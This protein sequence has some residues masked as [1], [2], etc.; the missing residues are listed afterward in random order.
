MAFDCHLHSTHSSDAE[1]PILDMCRSA[2]DQGI[3]AVCFT[4]HYDLDPMDSKYDRFHHERYRADIDRARAAFDG[5]VEILTGIE[6]SEPHKYPKE[7][8]SMAG[9]GFDCILGSMH[10]IGDTWAGAADIRTKYSLEKIFEIHYAETLAMVRFGGFDALAHMD[11][12]RRFFDDYREPEDL[13]NPILAALVRNGIAL[14]LNSSPLR[15]GKDFSLPSETILHRYRELGGVFV[16]TGSDAH[17]AGDVGSG[18]EHLAGRI[19]IHGLRQVIYRGRNRCPV[20]NAGT[21][22]GIP[23]SGTRS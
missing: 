6:F 5:R 16:T 22:L 20:E 13:I 15:N 19:R 4:E 11:F 1:S 14:E 12:P 3:S 17:C 23:D 2:I 9:K 8:E 21:A 10:A 7:F 18:L